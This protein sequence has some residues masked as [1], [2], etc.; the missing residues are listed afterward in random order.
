MCQRGGIIRVVGKGNLPHVVPITAELEALLL[1]LRGHHPE[2][3]FTFVAERTYRNVKAGR[4][5]VAGEQY[6]IIYA[7]LSTRYRRAFAKADVK[8][9]RRH[10]L[11][12]TAATRIM[13]ETGNLKPTSKLLG[14]ASVTT[15]ARYAHVDLEDVRAGMEAVAKRKNLTKITGLH[16][17]DCTKRKTRKARNYLNLLVP[18]GGFE[19]PTYRLQSESFDFWFF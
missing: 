17:L 7:G 4:D 13:R 12:H 8:D 19:P 3:V 15:T 5:Y 14:H 2:L 9:F 11:R 10:D 6:P 1:P 16:K 18:R